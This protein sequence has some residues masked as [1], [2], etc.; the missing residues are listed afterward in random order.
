MFCNNNLLCCFF[1]LNFLGQIPRYRST[2]HAFKKIARHEGAL[3]LWRGVTPT[4][5]RAAIGTSAQIS[6]YD[7][8]KHWLLNTNRMREGLPLHIVSAM[9]SGFITAF[10]MSPIDVIKTRIMNQQV[11]NKNGNTYRNARDCLV[12]TFTSEGIFGLYKGFIPNWLRLGPHTITT[13]I[14]FEQ[15]RLYIG[16]DPV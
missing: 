13:F 9:M 5:H 2:M 1:H 12:K 15:L 7:H 10:I 3:G 4:V 16:L 6:S 14:L 11:Q 8:T